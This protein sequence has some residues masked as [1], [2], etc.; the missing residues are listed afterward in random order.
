MC[1]GVSGFFLG[2]DFQPVITKSACNLPERLTSIKGEGAKEFID[3]F[4]D[5][6]FHALYCVRCGEVI[7]KEEM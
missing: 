5:E 1:R 4:R 2:H 3:G 6:T 7:T